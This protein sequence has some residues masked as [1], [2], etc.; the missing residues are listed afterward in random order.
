[1]IAVVGIAG[2]RIQIPDHPQAE[3]LTCIL[4]SLAREV[5]QQ[6]VFIE[7]ANVSDVIVTHR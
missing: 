3:V 4:R 1:M 5:P 2:V 7:V 6:G